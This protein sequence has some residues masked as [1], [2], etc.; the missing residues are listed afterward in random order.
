MKYRRTSMEERDELFSH[1]LWSFDGYT[2]QKDYRGSPIITASQE[3]IDRL[4]DWITARLGEPVRIV[5]SDGMFM[6]NHILTSETLLC[7]RFLE[8]TA[9]SAL[10][11]LER[12]R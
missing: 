1:E 5:L 4:S 8:D 12:S 6:L 3:N 7:G 11:T 9:L 10:D 2:L